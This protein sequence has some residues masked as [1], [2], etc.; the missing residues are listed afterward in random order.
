MSNKLYLILTLINLFSNILS[1]YNLPITESIPSNGSFVFNYFSDS[2]CKNLTNTIGFIP[3]KE[4]WINSIEKK[5]FS[6]E[7]FK[8]ETRIL[9]FTDSNEILCNN[10]EIYKISDNLYY[11][12]NFIENYLQSKFVFKGFSDKHCNNLNDDEYS[13]YLG[14]YCWKLKGKNSIGIQSFYGRKIKAYLF[15]NDNCI[16]NF[17]EIDFDCNEKCFK[18]NINNE[19]IYYTCKFSKSKFI[20]INKIILIAILLIF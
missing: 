7:S 11:K 16:G 12:C 8:N 3:T 20:L 5:T 4:K 18:N 1:D 14:D 2:E 15:E 10:E 6:I 19:K 13:F 9:K 17:N